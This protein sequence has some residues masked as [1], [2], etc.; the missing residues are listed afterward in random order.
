MIILI[1]LSF[2]AF[3]AFLGYCL[4]FNFDVQDIIGIRFLN[5][6]TLYTISGLVS[7]VLTSSYKGI[8]R[9]TGVQDGVRI[10]YMLIDQ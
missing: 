8:I 10:F 6:I 4:R 1:D 7:I 2:I 5:G 9:Y 3:S